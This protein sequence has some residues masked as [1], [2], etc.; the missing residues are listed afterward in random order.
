MKN[1][2]ELAEGLQHSNEPAVAELAKAYLALSENYDELKYQY[3]KITAKNV[4]EKHEKLLKR[5]AEG[6]D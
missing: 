6:E 1:Y 3:V 4:M 5:L 2:L